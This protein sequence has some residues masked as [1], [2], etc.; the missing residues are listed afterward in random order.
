MARFVVPA[1]VSTS[2]DLL[3]AASEQV[4]EETLRRMRSQFSSNERWLLVMHPYG[5]VVQALSQ[6]ST[7]DGAKL[8][9]YIAASIPLH[10]ADGWIFLAR[11]FDSI[12]SGDRNT[13]VHLAYYAELRAAMSLLASEGIGVFKNRHVAIDQ[14]YFP[15]V[16][17]GPSTHQAT[18]DLLQSW[19]DDPL[20]VRT[21]LTAIKVESRT[22]DE[23]F[24]EAGISQ[25]VQHLVAREWLRSWS[26]DLEIFPNDRDLR[27]HTSYRPSRMSFSPTRSI[28]T[29]M[30]VID[31]LLRTWD[32]LEPSSDIGGAAIDRALLFRALHLAHNQPQVPQS[33]WDI[34]VD[35]LSGIASTS[36]ESQLRDP[37]M[38]EFY[39][40]KWADDSSTP[41]LMQAILA[42]ATLLLRIA[43]GVCAQRLANAEVAKQELQFWWTNLGEDG[44]FWSGDSKPDQF[45]DLW[46]E[47]SHALDDVEGVLEVS[48]PSR[49]M[50]QI[51]Q[52]FGR[53]AA[54]TQFSRVPLWLLGVDSP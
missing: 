1:P 42:R 8:A 20:R 38:N 52:I 30:E 54:L 2:S 28:D 43:N 25:L 32:A 9:E 41:P 53:N 45:T 34:F 18:W 3:N 6:S 21:L 24:D 19:A 15:T 40:L 36:L 46:A 31:P 16:W 12:R 39:V 47:V 22:L 13:A 4:I 27:N 5:D 23:W 17:K 29:S 48:Q 50:S 33:N 14:T 10:V 11:A 26:I 37:V 7:I 44:G 51:S 49:T 35:R